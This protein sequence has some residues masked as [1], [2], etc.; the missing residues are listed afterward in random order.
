M[1]KNKQVSHFGLLGFFVISLSFFI[2]FFL[3]LSPKA[4]VVSGKPEVSGA[5]SLVPTEGLLGTITGSISYPS[6]FIP[7][8]L[9]VCA[10]NVYNRGVFCTQDKIK[11][12]SYEYGVG[13]KLNLP[14][15]SYYVYA[16]LPN[17]DLDKVAYKA[18]YSE[19]VL[20][21]LEYSCQSHDPVLIDVKAGSVVSDVDPQDWYK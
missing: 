4:L 15:G 20:C 3:Y 13:Y 19:F 6:E 1:K 18:Y 14:E 2:F 8:K 12:S 10:E 16:Y 7:E 21:G 9:T 11:D 5:T 17:E